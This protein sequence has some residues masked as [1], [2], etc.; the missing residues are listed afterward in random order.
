MIDMYS[1]AMK[2][3][4]CHQYHEMPLDAIVLDQAG[5]E[6]HMTIATSETSVT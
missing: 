6:Y 2:P 1:G 3:S 4:K 5:Q